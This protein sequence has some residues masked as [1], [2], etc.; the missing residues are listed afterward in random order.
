MVPQSAGEACQQGH[1]QGTPRIVGLQSHPMKKSP[2]GRS[3]QPTKACMTAAF[4]LEH[5]ANARKKRKTD[6]AR[7]RRQRMRAEH[8]ELK[9]KRGA[10]MMTEW[11]ELGCLG[12]SN[13]HARRS[14][15]SHRPSAAAQSASVCR[16][17]C[18]QLACNWASQPVSSTCVLDSMVHLV[19]ACAICFL[20]L[21]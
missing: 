12:Q 7:A 5:Q 20:A 9:A 16:T 11:H 4:V 19:C 15:T 14:E 21:Q 6:V 2:A 17:A 8:R 3:M 1:R 13:C 18:V 10:M